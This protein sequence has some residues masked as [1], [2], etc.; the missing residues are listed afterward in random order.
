MEASRDRPEAPEATNSCDQCGANFPSHDALER[1]RNMA[2]PEGPASVEAPS[3]P[4]RPTAAEWRASRPEPTRDP[5]SWNDRPPASNALDDETGEAE[6]ETERIGTEFPGQDMVPSDS[7]ARDPPES[8]SESRAFPGNHRDQNLP[9]DEEAE[10]T[11]SDARPP[12]VAPEPK[13]PEENAGPRNPD[14]TRPP[15]GRREARG[16][17]SHRTKKLKKSE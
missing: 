3:E 11:D 17:T 16:S 15:I 2:H 9:G 10:E 1:H 4:K 6:D 5:P 13:D 12:N 14:C 7:T 8:T